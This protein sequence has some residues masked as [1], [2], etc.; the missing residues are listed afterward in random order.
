MESNNTDFRLMQTSFPVSMLET[1]PDAVDYYCLCDQSIA[2]G[3]IMQSWWS[4]L[5]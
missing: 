4:S 3:V 2:A 5:W 1:A